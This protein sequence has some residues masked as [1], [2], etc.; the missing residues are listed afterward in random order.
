MYIVGTM[1]SHHAVVLLKYG[2][3]V[4]FLAVFVAEL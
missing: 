3:L 2:G 1:Q 4:L